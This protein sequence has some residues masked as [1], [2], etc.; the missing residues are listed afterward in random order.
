MPQEIPAVAISG[1]LKAFPAW[2]K[3]RGVGK[4]QFNH[5]T[6]GI[7]PSDYDH[8]MEFFLTHLG[9]LGVTITREI[10]DI[11]RVLYLIGP[12]YA[13]KA[14]SE[15][16]EEFMNSKKAPEGVKKPKT[17]VSGIVRRYEV[18]SIWLPFSKTKA[19]EYDKG[20]K[21]T[22]ELDSEIDLNWGEKK[23]TFSY[24][25]Y[26][27]ILFSEE[28]WDSENAMRAVN[29]ILTAEG[30]SDSKY[31]WI[32]GI[33]EKE[34]S[35]IE[36]LKNIS[37]DTLDDM[38]GYSLEIPEKEAFEFK[39]LIK[40][41]GTES[42]DLLEDKNKQEYKKHFVSAICGL[43][44]TG[45]S[46][47]LKCFE[48]IISPTQLVKM[49]S[50]LDPQ[51]LFVIPSSN[52]EIPFYFEIMR[53][54]FNIIY[55]KLSFPVLNELINLRV[56]P[57]ETKYLDFYPPKN[58]LL[59]FEEFKSKLK[60]YVKNP[61]VGTHYLEIPLLLYLNSDGDDE[62]TKKIKKTKRGILSSLK[63]LGG[64]TNKIERIVMNIFKSDKA[65][66]VSEDKDYDNEATHLVEAF[67]EKGDI[68]FVRVLN[69]RDRRYVLKL[70]Y[71]P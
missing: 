40:E 9:K 33:L 59:S 23:C 55:P 8:G 58:K 14:I 28:E 31:K 24:G 15:F 2:D 4:W 17:G 20:L 19:E 71:N 37:D 39:S 26:E 16:D 65:E 69:T 22:S 44:Y 35:N 54:T 51:D 60:R 63:D 49:V 29:L 6:L 11:S 7:E 27:K 50:N 61:K 70:V 1:L 12:I 21:F 57:T 43:T 38:F 56:G 45:P 30:L 68:P 34:L 67:I 42:L 18:P 3:Y 36:D 52:E 5:S 46:E 47:L 13:S 53:S 25:G 10:N 48:T 32:K 64:D 62:E 41:K 66:D